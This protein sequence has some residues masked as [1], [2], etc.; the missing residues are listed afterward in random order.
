MFGLFRRDPVKKLEV[1]Y[2]K[3]LEEAR[4]LQ[5]KGDIQGFAA[6]TART[7]ALAQQIDA[8][9]AGKKQAKG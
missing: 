4:D 8:I 1:E 2:R 5:R 3:L 7:E 6:M 9:K